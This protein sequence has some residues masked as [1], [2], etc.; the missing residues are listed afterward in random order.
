M[1]KLKEFVSKLRQTK[2]LPLVCAAV[3]ACVALCA[4]AFGGK[5]DKTTDKTTDTQSYIDELTNKIVSVIQKIDG[6]GRTEVAVTAATEGAKEYAYETTDKV[7]GDKSTQT[8]SLVI[9][10]GKPLVVKSYAPQVLGVVVVCQGGDDPIVRMKVINAVVT[11]TGVD[12]D[13]V[14]VFTYK[15]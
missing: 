12:R 6:C 13:N 4:V 2:C 1:G 11:L 3:L 14:R 7:V 5:I 8:T 15:V 9:V 10:D